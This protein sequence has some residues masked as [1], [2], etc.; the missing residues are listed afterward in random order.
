LQGYDVRA[1]HVAEVA[2]DLRSTEFDHMLHELERLQPVIV[3]GLI[4]REAG[5]FYNSAVAID[6]GKVIAR[7][8]KANLLKG[9]Q[10]IFEPGDGF[11]IFDDAGIKVGI[12]I[13][14]DLSFAESIR[15]AAAAGAELLACPCSNMMPRKM[16]EGWK[17]RHNEMRSR[18]AREQ[19]VWIVSSDV[20][21][22][23]DGWISYGP[24]AVIDPAGTV[25]D[26]VPLL[27]T[28]MVVAEI[29]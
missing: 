12:N 14:Y 19:G 21:G 22:E 18:Y 5:T 3:V 15:R 17:P 13:C 29:A 1:E 27:E 24:T 28:G 11:P 23:R 10:S 4:E 7:Y 8:R 6:G 20:T 2:I 25:I 9:E 26:Q 16:A